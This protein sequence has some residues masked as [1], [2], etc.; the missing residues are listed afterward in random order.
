MRYQIFIIAILLSFSAYA[1]TAQAQERSKAPEI[2]LEEPYR[3]TNQKCEFSFQLP[4]AP[5]RH[6]IWGEAK[7]PTKLVQ[8]PGYGEVGEKV[9][10]HVRSFDKKIHFYFSAH[11]LYPEKQFFSNI[12]KLDMEKELERVSKELELRNRAISVQDLGQGIVLG[13]MTGFQ[14][15]E[16]QQ[17]KA[18][19]IQFMKGHKSLLILTNHYSADQP[20]Y[21]SVYKFIQE[22]MV[23]ESSSSS[24]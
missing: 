14:V 19:F 8:N 1:Y 21:S 11:C 7:L 3:Y 4:E 9:E 13:S 17:V 2:P 22:S 18:F 6:A 10:Y 23:F 16:E 5:T 15:N 20:Q 12:E 24:P